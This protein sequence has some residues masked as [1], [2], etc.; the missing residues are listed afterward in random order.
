M[1]SIPESSIT[2]PKPCWSRHMARLP[3]SPIIVSVARKISRRDAVH[4]R[5]QYDLRGSILQT[6]LN[7]KNNFTCTV[8]V[9]APKAKS[10]PLGAGTACCKLSKPEMARPSNG[11]PLGLHNPNVK[12]TVNKRIKDYQNPFG[13]INPITERGLPHPSHS[14]WYHPET[15]R[16]F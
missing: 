5:S 6:R 2:A 13:Y 10:L 4:R 7:Q 3:W 8:N 11:A 12:F 1:V 14:N 16:R 9:Q 15:A